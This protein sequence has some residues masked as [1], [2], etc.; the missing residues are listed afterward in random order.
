MV[1]FGAGIT[2]SD[3]QVQGM[4]VWTGHYNGMGMGV[5]LAQE[6]EEL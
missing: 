6:A 5:P 4:A 2:W 1:W 3:V